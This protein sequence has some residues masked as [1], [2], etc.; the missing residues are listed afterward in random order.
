MPA[1]ATLTINNFAAT[2]VNYN[3]LGIKDGVARWADQTQGTVGGYKTITAEVRSPSDPS[4]Q[5]T[6]I[7]FNIARPIV[8]GTTGVVDYITRAKI[9]ILEPPGATLAE[10]QEIFAAVKNLAAH[11]FVSDA[12]T[13]QE[14]MY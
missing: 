9:E 8:N 4:K 2:P 10:R 13:K 3:V 6:R 5:V 12:V 11:T 14:N 7:V 1:M